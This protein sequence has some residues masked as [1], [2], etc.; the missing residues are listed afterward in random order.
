MTL[1]E[2][3][4]DAEATVIIHPDF[5]NREAPGEPPTAGGRGVAA[6]KAT[7][8]WLH[9]TYEGLRW[10][11]HDVVGSGDVV[12]M[13]TTMRGRQKAPFATYHPDGRPD[14]VFAS[15]GREFA[16]TQTHWY[17]IADGRIIEHWAN[18]D[19]LGQAQQL[20]W[21]PPSPVFLLRSAVAKRR[22]PRMPGPGVTAG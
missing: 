10:E 1:M 9:G 22:L 7:Y 6:G 5:V 4:D 21:V 15:N 14:Q 12:A 13:H 19:D 8:E 17:R 20:G 11:V 16:T 18:R 2:G 3:W